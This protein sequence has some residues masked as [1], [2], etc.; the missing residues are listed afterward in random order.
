MAIKETGGPRPEGQKPVKSQ[1]P[2]KIT[3][4][5]GKAAETAPRTPRGGETRKSEGASIANRD[6][7]RG[8]ETETPHTLESALSELE[9]TSKGIVNPKPSRVLEAMLEGIEKDA[10]MPQV[11]IEEVAKRVEEMVGESKLPGKTLSLKAILG[12]ISQ[13]T[14]EDQKK[15][16]EHLNKNTEAAINGEA[17]KMENDLK[18]TDENLRDPF[19]DNETK[20]QMIKEAVG[21]MGILAHLSAIGVIIK[22]GFEE[23]VLNNLYNI[24][25]SLADSIELKGYEYK[26]IFGGILHLDVLG[27]LRSVSERINEHN[28]DRFFDL[29]KLF[30]NPGTSKEGLDKLID[31]LLDDKLQK[32][33]DHAL[34]LDVLVTIAK[35]CT[36]WQISETEANNIAKMMLTNWNRMEGQHELHGL[37]RN[38][39]DK[40]LLN[41]EM[42][43]QITEVVLKNL[44]ELEGDALKQAYVTLTWLAW[45]GSTGINEKM[46]DEMAKAILKN[47]DSLD[48][49]AQMSAY[50]A[51]QWLAD[52]KINSETANEM[53]E[54]IQ[55]NVGN[56]T[57]PVQDKAQKILKALESKTS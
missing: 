33:V 40:K 24:I 11:N 42:V 41:E 38:L 29:I 35:K 1:E 21:K 43:K 8:A 15:V 7:A 22:K 10:D 26:V 28:Q 51:L 36:I 31:L 17:N 16:S 32:K 3:V 49:N 12:E 30:I 2:V 13:L 52:S 14:P 45:L 56:L 53:T 6:I 57:G 27:N 50:R 25:S 54:V 4:P 9:R 20:N 5:Q 55:K 47:L 44:D 37:L 19:I 23:L 48:G 46:V 34:I 18:M 39:L